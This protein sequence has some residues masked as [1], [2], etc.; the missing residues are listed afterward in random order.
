MADILSKLT[1]SEAWRRSREK[2]ASLDLVGYAGESAISYEEFNRIL[3]TIQ[4]FL[5][6]QGIIPGDKVA[7]ISESRPEWGLVYV[8]VTTMGAIVVPVMVDCSSEQIGN[9]LDHSESRYLFA[10][11]R[12]LNKMKDSIFVRENRLVILDDGVKTG[13]CSIHDDTVTFEGDGRDLYQEGLKASS[14]EDLTIDMEED[15][16]AAILYTSG[17]TGVSKGVMLSHK[18]IT[19]N[20]MVGKPIPNVLPNENFLSVL[21]LAHSYE[22]TL[23]LIL[24]IISGAGIRYIK[25][26][27]T[28]RIMLAALSKVRPEHMLTVPILIEKIYRGSILPKFNNSPVLRVLYKIR[29][30]QYVLNRFAAGKKLNDLFGGR[31]KFF[32]IGGAPLAPDV[33]VFLRDA[34]FPYSCGYGLTETA[35]CLAGAE[36]VNSIYRAIGPAFRDVELRIADVNPETGHGEIQ[37]K[38]PNIMLGYYKDEEKTKEVFTEDGWFRTGDLGYLTKKGILYIKGRLKNMILGPNGENI[39]PE[40]IEAVIN[41][42]P[43]VL[44][45]LVTRMGNGLVARVQLNTEKLDE[46]I[47]NLKESPEELNR[48]KSEILETI[49]KTANDRLSVLSRL[50]DMIEQVEPFEKTPSLKIKRFLY[51]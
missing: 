14:V 2:Y 45:S 25:G 29:P 17:T 23:G 26:A 50:S 51:T 44:E 30:F 38:G 40:E 32:G 1:L 20:A 4:E 37:A 46:F 36:P 8:A 5:K 31:L 19:H 48:I 34:R 24:P 9:I 18:N 49:R 41:R 3:S 7:L 10:S 35:P 47:Q 6:E 16:I 21:P 27:P 13:T 33:E 43:F 39:Y 28:A 11:A 12:V 42:D 22:C 15:D